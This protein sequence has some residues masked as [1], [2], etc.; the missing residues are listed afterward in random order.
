MPMGQTAQPTKVCLG[1]IESR[2]QVKSCHC[3]F[4][5]RLEMHGIVNTFT[6]PRPI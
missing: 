2:I 3:I 4:Y 5:H 6:E 1:Q